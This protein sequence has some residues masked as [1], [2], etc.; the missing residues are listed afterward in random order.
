M[1]ARTIATIP[2]IRCRLLSTSIDGRLNAEGTMIDDSN[3]G[4]KVVSAQR[5]DRLK[6]VPKVKASTRLTQ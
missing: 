5:T 3:V 1:S 6:L 4:T 2:D